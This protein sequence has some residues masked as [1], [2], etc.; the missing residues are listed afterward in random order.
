WYPAEFGLSAGPSREGSPTLL[1]ATWRFG[2]R[3]VLKAFQKRHDVVGKRF[4]QRT[5]EDTAQL[6]SDPVLLLALR[7][8]FGR[9]SRAESGLLHHVYFIHLFPLS[10]QRP[11]PSKSR[12]VRLPDCQCGRSAM[13]PDFLEPNGMC[14]VLSLYR[15]QHGGSYA[16]KSVTG[17]GAASATSTALCTRPDGWAGQRRRLCAGVFA[18]YRR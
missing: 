6:P 4:A 17:P 7:A 16:R 2:G 10:A 13:V 8:R 12:A 1:G 14:H 9:G 5:V 18:G 3:R 15:V 11:R